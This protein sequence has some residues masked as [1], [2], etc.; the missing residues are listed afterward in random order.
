MKIKT[1]NNYNRREKL[2]S[3]LF[4][5]I[6]LIVDEL[7]DDRVAG[8]VLVRSVDLTPDFS[9]V[10]IYV[11]AMDSEVD[12]DSMLEGLDHAKGHIRAELAGRLNMKKIPELGFVYDSTE[13]IAQRL[14]AIAK[15][16][17]NENI[18]SEDNRQE[19]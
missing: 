18:A 9:Y 5:E 17:R 8:N 2:E 14:E 10:R 4:E 12:R 13:E 11:S 19:D 7:T 3:L 15:E 1:H 6:T 16:I